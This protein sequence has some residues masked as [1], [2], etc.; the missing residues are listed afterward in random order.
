MYYIVLAALISVFS[1]NFFPHTAG[2]VVFLL[3]MTFG[4]ATMSFCFMVSTLFSHARTASIVGM[5]LYFLMHVHRCCFF[6]L[7]YRGARQA[8]ITKP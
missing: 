5:V 7:A 6:T 8:L 3:F 1:A 4:L 2:A